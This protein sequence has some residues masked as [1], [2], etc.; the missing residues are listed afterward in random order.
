MFF[1]KKNCSIDKMKIDLILVDCIFYSFFM[2]K[3]DL[4]QFRLPKSKKHQALQPMKMQREKILP[5]CFLNANSHMARSRSRMHSLNLI[6]DREAD[7]V[8]R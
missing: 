2:S 5:A 8:R 7:I 4:L 3:K 6:A 1:G